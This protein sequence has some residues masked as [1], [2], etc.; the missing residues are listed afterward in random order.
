VTRKA[1]E[2]ADIYWNLKSLQNKVDSVTTDSELKQI[3]T[4]YSELL[5]RAGKAESSLD[6]PKKN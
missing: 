5:K 4:Q 3:S 1:A 6:Q 2:F